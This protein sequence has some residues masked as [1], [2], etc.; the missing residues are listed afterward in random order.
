LAVGSSNFTTGPVYVGA[1]S[2]DYI[3]SNI[4]TRSAADLT[5]S[6]S[7]I[8]V[9]SGYYSAAASKN[10]GAGSA[11]TP[12]TTITANPTVTINSSTGLITATVSK[13]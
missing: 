7:Y 12:A 2:S 3:G 10:V 11:K 4:A 6:G 13:S 5:A 1:I 9:P 8:N